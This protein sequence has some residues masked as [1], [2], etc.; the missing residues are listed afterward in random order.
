MLSQADLITNSAWV[1]HRNIYRGKNLG[2][3]ITDEQLAAIRDGSF[4][5]LYVGDYWEDPVSKDG[6]GGTVK[7]LIADINYW[8]AKERLNETGSYSFMGN[9]IVVIPHNPLFKARMNETDTV[10]TGFYGSSMFN[11][12]FLQA[13][14]II[15][16]F[17]EKDNVL[18]HHNN[19][20]SSFSDGQI[21]SYMGINTKIELPNEYAIVGSRNLSRNALM[22]SGLTDT[23]TNRQLAIFSLNPKAAAS[24]LSYWTPDI[25]N[26]QNYV[27]FWSVG[28]FGGQKASSNN[29]GV[30]PIFAVG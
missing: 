11:E 5:D 6:E 17:F 15:Y 27:V 12:S 7:W 22:N 16:S 24:H 23:W 14:E 13:A 8:I 26:T 18:T 20:S 25:I 19:F 1:A 3:E 10:T 21:K 4:K 29:I 28:D 2:N 30:R 9:H